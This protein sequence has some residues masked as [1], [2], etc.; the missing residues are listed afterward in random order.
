MGFLH[1]VLVEG[2]CS[3]TASPL[4]PCACVMQHGIGFVTDK[5]KSKWQHDK[6]MI[7]N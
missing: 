5:R 7:M 4:P 3:P 2:G 1:F 6:M